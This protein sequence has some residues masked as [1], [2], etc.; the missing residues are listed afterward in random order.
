[1]IGLSPMTCI[2]NHNYDI[3]NS[4]CTCAWVHKIQ[5]Q[6]V[7]EKQDNLIVVYKY[8]IGQ[9]CINTFEDH[10]LHVPTPRHH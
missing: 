7:E 6:V 3:Q 1:M 5:V 8:S 2:N 4:V 10:A 9:H